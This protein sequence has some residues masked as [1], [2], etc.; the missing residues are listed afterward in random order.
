MAEPPCPARRQGP[1]GGRGQWGGAGTPQTDARR[2]GVQAAPLFFPGSLAPWL[3]GSRRSGPP[4]LAQASAADFPRPFSILPSPFRAPTPRRHPMRRAGEKTRMGAVLRAA[5]TGRQDQ[6][7]GRRLSSLQAR[8]GVS[9]PRTDTPGPQA[10]ARTGSPPKHRGKKPGPP[11]G[12]IRATWVSLLAQRQSR[13]K[14]EQGARSQRLAERQKPGLPAPWP[15]FLAAT[16]GG[17]PPQNGN[18]P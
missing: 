1:T 4:N 13:P 5:K 16:P 6:G 9:V 17:H 11:H 2:P 15:L 12:P 7:R 8:A 3:P 14:K 10:G 18:R